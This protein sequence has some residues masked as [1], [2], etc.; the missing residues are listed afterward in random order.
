MLRKLTKLVTNNFGLKVLGT[1][2]AVIL[3]LAIVNAADPDATVL[4]TATVKIENADYLENMGKT[5]EVLNDSDVVSFYVK[6]RRSVVDNLTASDF[7][8]TANMENIDETMSK[9]PITVTAASYGNQIEI[10]KKNSFVNINVENRMTAQFEIEV[11]TEGDLSAYCYVKS[12]SVSPESVSVSGPQSVVEQIDSAEVR[13]NTS[14]VSDDFSTTESIVLLDESGTEVSQERLVLSVS[15]AKVS[16]A[17]SMRKTVPLE[18]S[19]TGDP[20]DGYRYEDLQSSVSSITLE[21]DPDDLSSVDSLNLSPT[22]LNIS[23]ITAGFTASIPLADYLPDGVKLAKGEPETVQ[24]TVNLEAQTNNTFEMPTGN[25]VVSGLADGL[26]L[27]FNTETVTV[28]ITGFEDEL[29]AIKAEDLK[30]TLDAS[31]L[32]SGVHTVPITISGDY[33][34]GASASAA[35]TITDTNNTEE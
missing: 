8:V 29:S 4:L 5:Y 35:I 11:V 19:V 30:G 18:F 23:G 27:S 21:G 13:V 3:W 14:G 31:S 7:T 2:F 33:A 12:S 28:T 9:V 25:V 26:T 10:T 1:V 15:E 22:Q 34:S 24:V 6:G 20:A 17:I 32:G 16:L